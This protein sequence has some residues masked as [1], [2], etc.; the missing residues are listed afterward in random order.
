MADPDPQEPFKRALAAT[1]RALSG[2]GGMEVSFGQGPMQQSGDQVQVPL[3]EAREIEADRSSIRGLTDECA[4]RLKYHDRAEHAR[5]APPPGI[6]RDLFDAAE[7]ARI[8]AVG[9]QSMLGVAANLDHRLDVD[10]GRQGFTDAG[11]GDEALIGT[12]VGL[13]IRE[14]LTERPL[15]PQ[16][17]RILRAWRGRIGAAVDA[18]IGQLRDLVTDQRAYALRA[19]QLVEGLGLGENLV[20]PTGAEEQPGDTSESTD[21]QDA[22]EGAESDMASGV[23]EEMQEGDN[24]DF[25][26]EDVETDPDLG[27]LNLDRKTEQNAPGD[28]D[29]SGRILPNKDY[30]VYSTRFD[31]IVKAGDL[32]PPGEMIRLRGLLD[33]QMQ[34]LHHG[35]SRLANRLQRRLLAK[36]QRS[37]EFELEEGVLDTAKLAGLI[38]NPANT[39]AYKQEKEVDFRDTVT[40]LLIDNSGSMR[41]RSIT[42]AAICAEI[43]GRTLERCAT[44]V[45]IL[46]FTTRAWRGGQARELWLSKGKKLHPGRL[47]DLR[48][49]IYKS[50]D[51]PWRQ[52]RRDL[53]LM[54]REE[55]LKENIDGEAL[56]WAHNRLV[57]RAERRKLLMVISDGLPVDNS[58]LLSNPS[59]YL[60]RHLDAVI[61]IIEEQSPVELT[62]IGIGH[63]VTRHYRRAVT[64]TDADQLAGAMVGQLEELFNVET[65]GPGSARS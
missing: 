43:L 58:T 59:D 25:S 40:T 14:R 48:H 3:S 28:L 36:Q 53:G 31:E 22:R 4:L 23:G 8:A 41:G 6:G 17:E 32:C 60:E 55:L 54:M 21:D 35:T 2:R 65:P 26:Q 33:Q 34:A 56:I 27:D 1:M 30:R 20:P 29:G 37:W 5:M 47:N 38:A 51:E 9:V 16:A 15:P 19:L 45:E 46:G 13:L 57:V 52:A 7:R 63:D 12:A 11:C 10:C 50:A 61:R 64:I 49:I 44:R 42:I 18:H 62:A 24:I 39:L